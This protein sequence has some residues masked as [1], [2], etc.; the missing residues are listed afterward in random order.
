MQFQMHVK[1]AIADNDLALLAIVYKDV[2]CLLH[3]VPYPVADT[4][5]LLPAT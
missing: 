1:S 5:P 2:D 3:R 4:H